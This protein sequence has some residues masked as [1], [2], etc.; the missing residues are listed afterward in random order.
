[1]GTLATVELYDPVPDEDVLDHVFAWLHEVDRRFSTYQDQSEVNRLH[2][3]EL[4][5]E[6]GSADLRFV[7]DQC[8]RLWRETDGFFD[9]YATG[10]LDPSGYV[11]GWSVQRA[12]ELLTA[13]G[14]TNHLI[15]VGGDI[16]SRGRPEPG[17]QWEIGI[18]HPW[19][20]DKVAW[21]LAGTD[22]AVA[23]SGTYE[24]GGHVINPRTGRPATVLR[25]VT[26]VGRDLADADAYATAALAMGTAALSWLARLTG[27][28][29]AVVAADETCYRSNGLPEMT[30]DS[31]QAVEFE[32]TLSFE[33]G[34]VSLPADKVTLSTVE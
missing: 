17:R 8:A 25:S 3:G 32:P 18:R 24:R 28:E 26:V 1:M 27:Y 2:R 34:T 33:Q 20:L 19:E 22:L 5:V 23:T 14:A 16:Q 12:S 29:A 9:A 15:E 11:K 7:L 30:T 4:T 31:G 13:A 10:R 6:Q 21:V